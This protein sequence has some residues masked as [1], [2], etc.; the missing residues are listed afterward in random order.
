MYPI[1]DK[2]N[3]TIATECSDYIWNTAAHRP[4][5]AYFYKK[6]WD[7]FSVEETPVERALTWQFEFEEL[8]RESGFSLYKEPLKSA[9]IQSIIWEKLIDM[10]SKSISEISIRP[11]IQESTTTEPL[12]LILEGSNID[13]PFR[14]YIL[15]SITNEPVEDGY[16]HPAERY[17]ERFL[18]LDSQGMV[19]WIE[20]LLADER[21]YSIAASIIK[22]IGRVKLDI[23]KGW[24]FRII[25]IALEHPDVEVRDSAA[26]ALEQWGTLQAKDLLK[27]HIANEEVPWLGDYMKRV[28]RDMEEKQV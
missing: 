14:S 28:I 2:K 17:I 12:G 27:K 18:L 7:Y 3:P 10:I 24:G 6:M 26:Q 20:D 4:G 8:P 13:I 1:L 16:S 15:S 9:L 5:S 21:S 19:N 22:C 25:E 23:C 11:I